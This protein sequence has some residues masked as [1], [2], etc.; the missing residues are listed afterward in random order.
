MATLSD[1]DS[2]DELQI[3]E[4]PPP[5][6]RPSLPS[7]KKLAGKRFLPF[8]FFCLANNL[9]ILVQTNTWINVL[10]KVYQGNYLGP[11]HAATPTES[12]SQEKWTLI[13]RYASLF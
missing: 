5:R 1:F 11:N 10:I 3:D 6:R 7:K 2:E 9:N 4:T 13:L 12:V 8:I